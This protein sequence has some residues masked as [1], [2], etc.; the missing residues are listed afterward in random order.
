MLT[1]RWHSLYLKGNQFV[2]RILHQDSTVQR[3]FVL[4]ISGWKI[5]VCHQ[6][7]FPVATWPCERNLQSL[8]II[9]Y[10]ILKGLHSHLTVFAIVQK[11]NT[12]ISLLGW[13]LCVKYLS[14]R[15]RNVGLSVLTR[16]C[17]QTDGR[18][19][20]KTLAPP[21]PPPPMLRYATAGDKQQSS[22]ISRCVGSRGSTYC[23]CDMGPGTFFS[24]CT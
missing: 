2:W 8:D 20:R 9:V 22:S 24:F 7:E 19:D 14:N 1:F 12:S 17:R 18:T 11:K 15:S 3:G 23:A 6:N 4:R 10:I 13:A 5:N 16:K 21:P